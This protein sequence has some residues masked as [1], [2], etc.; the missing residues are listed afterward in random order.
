MNGEAWQTRLRLLK[1]AQL[2]RIPE[3]WPLWRSLAYSAQV[4]SRLPHLRE[5]S[6]RLA[7]NVHRSS[8]DRHSAALVEP[9]IS[10]SLDAFAPRAGNETA[11]KLQR[12]RLCVLKPFSSPNE[13]GVLKVMFSPVI[14][15]IPRLPKFKEILQRYTLVL[16]PSW[17]GAADPGLLQY[18]Q[19]DQDVVVLAAPEVDFNFLTRL[20]SAMKP[21][22]IGPCDWVDPRVAE[23]FLASQ[24]QYDIVM[25]SLWAGWKRQDVLFRALTQLDPALRVALIG[26]PWDGGLKEHVVSAAKLYGV[27]KQLTFFECIPY[28]EVMKIVCSSRIGVLLSLKEG[29]NRFLAEAM[30][31]NLPVILLDKHVGGIVKNVVPDTGIIASERELASAIKSMLGSLESYRPRKWAEEN[32]S[33]VV[34]SRKLNA[35]LKE[36][37]LRRGETWSQDILVHSNSPECK[38]W[39]AASNQLVASDYE[40]L[41]GCFSST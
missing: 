19:C 3:A 13:K 8:R 25:V 38:Y 7:M 11:S 39:D 18:A 29:S 17:T 32:I 21:I 28:Q 41:Q 37:A 34:S 36:L 15:E 6:I 9:L 26:E 33:C 1:R 22:R 4:M 27:D 35:F 12:N 31:C 23:P 24:K 16:E 30:F 10:R 2:E 40:W 5:R 14:A 20:D